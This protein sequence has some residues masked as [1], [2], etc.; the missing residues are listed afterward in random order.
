MESLAIYA[1]I[2]YAAGAAV[3][4][5]VT[6]FA[7]GAEKFDTRGLDLPLLMF[8]ALANAVFWPLLALTAVAASI[9]SMFGSK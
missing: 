1:G 3:T 6:C 8:M 4:F 5:G 2:T 9:G 7:A